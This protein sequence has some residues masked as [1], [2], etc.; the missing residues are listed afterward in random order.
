MR[1]VQQNREKER[2]LLRQM[3]IEAYK[4]RLDR[5]KDKLRCC[6][7]QVRLSEFTLT[8]ARIAEARRTTAASVKE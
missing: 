5:F 2:A 6:E 1:W 8:E 4:D 3:G 7:R